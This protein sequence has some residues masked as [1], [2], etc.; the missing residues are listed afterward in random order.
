VG[1]GDGQMVGMAPGK[2]AVGVGL[3]PSVSVAVVVRV[4]D[5]VAVSLAVGVI[6]GVCV[7][8]GVGVQTA[9]ARLARLLRA[10]WP[11][12]LGC[13]RT[14]AKYGGDCLLERADGRDPAEV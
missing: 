6:V 13:L 11:T 4:G 9:Q 2:P 12:G 10:D 14:A 1:L 5:G 8:L 3:G 7:S